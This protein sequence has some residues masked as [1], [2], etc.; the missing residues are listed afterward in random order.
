MPE[1]RDD[2]DEIVERL[3]L[4][5]T[6]PA[7]PDP[8]RRPAGPAHHEPAAEA[9]PEVGDDGDAADDR[10]DPVDE[11][12]YRQVPTGPAR[13]MDRRR[14]M[15]WAAVLGPPV[16]LV[17]CTVLSLWLPSPVLLGAGLIFVAG[18]IFLISQ[19]PEHGP[20]RRDWPD[21]GAAL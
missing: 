19:L 16:L 20:S 11:Q 4:D 14:A 9:R 12:F 2:F 7:Q 13:P 10:P 15:A 3:G 21:D 6:F 8:P 18:V 1:R 5:L 17:I